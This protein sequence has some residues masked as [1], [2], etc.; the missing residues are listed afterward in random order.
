MEV[1]PVIPPELR[2][3]VQLDGGRF[4]TSDL[5]DLYR[6]V[7]N[8]N[9]RLK[10]LLSLESQKGL[11]AM[12]QQYM[13]WRLQSYL[14]GLI[15]QQSYQDRVKLRGLALC[16]HKIMGDKVVLY[17]DSVT[18][19]AG[20]AGTAMCKSRWACPVC[21]AKVMQKT[22]RQLELT[23][24]YLRKKGLHAVLATF[25]IQ[26][27]DFMP[28][29]DVT[30]VLFQTYRETF[31]RKKLPAI[32]A[33]NANVVHWIKI[34]EFTYGANGW[35]PH[36]HVLA[37]V[38]DINAMY[39]VEQLVKERF[40]VVM[41]RR[42]KARVLMLAANHI[43]APKRLEATL[44]FIDLPEA[45]SE[46]VY[47]SKKDG[48]IAESHASK[49][50]CGWGADLEMTGNYQKVASH[51]DHYTPHQ[52]LELARNGDEKFAKLYIEYCKATLGH[53]RISMSRSGIS[54]IIKKLYQADKA[55]QLIKKKDTGLE[56][57]AIFWFT[58]EEWR[59][60]NLLNDSMPIKATLLTLT[61]DPPALMTYLASLGISE[62]SYLPKIKE[63]S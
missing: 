60:I 2:P 49:Y 51:A 42:L 24:D 44:K 36:F 26:H 29:A 19:K 25:T 15:R 9:N 62:K 59:Y 63:A 31:A 30:E 43:L 50:V 17:K 48:K 39:E 13:D 56:L 1:I 7:I 11:C 46:C 4:A 12:E 6:R 20:F 5:N 57:V 54:A 37:W 18:G 47:F 10:R 53:I 14:Q 23:L 3:M 35:H 61:R 16:T 58:K 33:W 40:S 27:F 28:C 55:E 34:C 41:K 21:T 22:A 8:R 52:M 45:G 32:K 38:K